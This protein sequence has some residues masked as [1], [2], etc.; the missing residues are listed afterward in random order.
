V[1]GEGDG[2]LKVQEVHRKWEKGVRSRIL[3][4]VGSR[5]NWKKNNT[6]MHNS[7]QSR[8]WQRGRSQKKMG[9]D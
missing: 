1:C 7:L 3:K 4:V 2:N 5:K 8:K 9:W 6:I